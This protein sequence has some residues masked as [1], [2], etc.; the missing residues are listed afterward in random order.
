MAD[1]FRDA[2]D[3]LLANLRLSCVKERLFKLESKGDM[4]ASEMD[5]Q[6]PVLLRV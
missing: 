6:K 2:F 5:A 4:Y 3:Q 1:D